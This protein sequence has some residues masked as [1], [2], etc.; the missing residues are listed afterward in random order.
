MGKKLITYGMDTDTDSSFIGGQPKIQN[1]LENY[2]ITDIFELFK[3]I[4]EYG[5]KERIINENELMSIGKL[6]SKI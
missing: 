2:E 4:N 5:F 1:E 3:Q 6:G